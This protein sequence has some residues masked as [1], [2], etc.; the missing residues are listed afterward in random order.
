MKKL[1]IILSILLL[2][3][4]CKKEDTSSEV[5]NDSTTAINDSTFNNNDSII[6]NPDSSTNFSDTSNTT[7]KNKKIRYLAL[8]DSY[9]I[10][11]SEIPE[12]RF[13]NQLV[14][15]LEKDSIEFVEFDIIAQSGWKTTDLQNA[16]NREN[17]PSDYNLVSLLIG[18][19]NQFQRADTGTYR[20]DFTHLLE[21]AI[22]F[23]GGDKNLVFVLSI[24]DYGYTPFGASSKETIEDEINWYNSVNKE[25]TLKYGVKYYNITEISRQVETDNELLASDQLHPSGKMYKLWVE[26]FY[27]DILKLYK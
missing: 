23:A 16:I 17:P 15:K 26:L 9:T 1:L 27:D 6:T 12:N 21:Q 20:G 13:P 10:G 8:G 24:P 5:N 11:S 2:F 7:V 25:I 4:N 19:N 18:V 3:I 14:S 22:K